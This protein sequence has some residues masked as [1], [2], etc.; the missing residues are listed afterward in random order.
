MSINFPVQFSINKSNKKLNETKK[1]LE[2]ST[3]S[4]LLKNN[5]G[6]SQKQIAEI[7]KNYEEAY[8]IEKI[9]LIESSNSYKKGMIKNLGK[10]LLC[11]LE[12]N[13]QQQKS[14]PKDLP[15]SKEK[16]ISGYEKYLREEIL[17]TFN[18]AN[19]KAQEDDKKF[20]SEQ[21]KIEPCMSVLSWKGFQLPRPS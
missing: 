19:K 12:E 20:L 3:I 6:L 10:Y 13:Y 9:E 1:E 4:E 2:E 18:D 11:A 16:D 5:Y 15:K 14:A 7:V 21:E 17:K 8:I